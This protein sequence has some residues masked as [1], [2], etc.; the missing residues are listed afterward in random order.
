MGER[1]KISQQFQILLKFW[2]IPGKKQGKLSKTFQTS[3]LHINGHILLIRY[4][5]HGE[6]PV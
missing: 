5:L 4:H 6:V 1:L 3:Q 2:L